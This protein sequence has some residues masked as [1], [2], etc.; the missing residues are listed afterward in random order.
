MARVV[1]DLVAMLAATIAI[2]LALSGI[3]VGA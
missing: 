3:A 1:R 2:V